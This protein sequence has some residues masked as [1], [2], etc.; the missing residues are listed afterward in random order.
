[1]NGTLIWSTEPY[2]PLSLDVTELKI[3]LCR[4]HGRN[5]VAR[6]PFEEYMIGSSRRVKCHKKR[7]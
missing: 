6:M 1:M 7:P 3:S 5:W 2:S 4:S